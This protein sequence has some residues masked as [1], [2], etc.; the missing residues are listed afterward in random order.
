MLITT[1]TRPLLM[2]LLVKRRRPRFIPMIIFIRVLLER[3]LL[4]KPSF[5][6]CYV[7]TA[8]LHPRLILP[9]G[10][11]RVSDRGVSSQQRLK[12][13]SKVTAYNQESSLDIC[14]VS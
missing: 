8:F 1:L 2:M 9:G 3:L 10:R 6:D 12:N 13:I 7:A 5:G 4:H 11:F 14:K